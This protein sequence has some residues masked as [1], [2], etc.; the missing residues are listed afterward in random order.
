MTGMQPDSGMPSI[1]LHE[2]ESGSV[3]LPKAVRDR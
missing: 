2:G 1:V 3:L